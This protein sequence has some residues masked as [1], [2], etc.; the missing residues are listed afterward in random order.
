MSLQKVLGPL[1]SKSV[2]QGNGRTVGGTVGACIV[3]VIR[4]AQKEITI[5]NQNGFNTLSLGKEET[6]WKKS[7]KI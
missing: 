4:L 7:S 5:S 1:Q 2:Y 6:N 3:W